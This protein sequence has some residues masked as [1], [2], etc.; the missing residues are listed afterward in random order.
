MALRD[1]AD[2]INIRYNDIDEKIIILDAFNYIAVGNR[3]SLFIGLN[4]N[5]YNNV[6]QNLKFF[7]ILIITIIKR[8]Q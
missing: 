1:V 4:Y 5:I 6:R 7:Y 8:K 2:G 3:I